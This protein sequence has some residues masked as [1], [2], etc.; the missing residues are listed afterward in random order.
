M[1]SRA[2]FVGIYIPEE[3]KKYE[4]A[5]SRWENDLDSFVKF[6]E[7]HKEHFWTGYNNLKYDGQIVEWILRECPNWYDLSGLEICAKISQ[8]STDNIDNS[9]YGLFS[10]YREQD[11]TLKQLDLPCVWHF[12]NDVMATY[13]FY[14]IT[15]GQTDLKLYKGKNKL[16]D[17][18]IIEEEI[19][20][21]C[22][23]FGDVKIGAEWNKLDYCKISG[24]NE[25]ELKPKKINHFYGKKYK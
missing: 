15:I 21:K 20:L 10:R 8:E 22:T 23:N 11:L 13:Y 14:L 25:R 9:N 6:V 18:E 3:D 5:V 12:F 4:F 2:L 1:F 17:R 24:K 7:G 19:G 16:K